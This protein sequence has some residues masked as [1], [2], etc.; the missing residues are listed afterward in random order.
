MPTHKGTQTLKTSRLILRKAVLADAQPMYGNWAS[1]PEVTRFLTWPAHDSV[2]TTRRI[3]ESWIE[4]YAKDNYYQWMI[5]LKELG[6]PSG[7]SPAWIPTT[8][9]PL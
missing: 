1:D 3:L 2:E 5:V 8:G 9:S 4:G 7:P 6:Q